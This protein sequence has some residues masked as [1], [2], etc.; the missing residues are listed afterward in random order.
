MWDWLVSGSILTFSDHVRFVL[1]HFLIC[2]IVPPIQ[3]R[4]LRTF[5]SRSQKCSWIHHRERKRRW[6]AKG[7]E[8]SRAPGNHRRLERTNALRVSTQLWRQKYQVETTWVIVPVWNMEGLLDFVLL[9]V[10]LFRLTTCAAPVAT[11]FTQSIYCNSMQSCPLSLVLRK[12]IGAGSSRSNK[13]LFRASWG[14]S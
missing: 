14:H 2:S 4:K 9:K 7:T 5:R 12:F 3:T 8:R 6:V 13:K 10:Y 11:W 1:G